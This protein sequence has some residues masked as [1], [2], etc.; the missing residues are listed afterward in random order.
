MILPRA[1]EKYEQQD[2]DKLR[3]ALEL[4]VTTLEQLGAAWQV[5]TG[6]S[7][8]TTFDTAT[9]TLPQLAERMKAVIEDVVIR[10]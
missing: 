5:P 2:Q 3:R 9:I 6:T 8:R 10:K 4:A 7:T 1:P